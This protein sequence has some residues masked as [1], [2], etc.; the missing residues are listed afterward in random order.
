[1]Q[2]LPP[3]DREWKDIANSFWQ[4][5]NFPNCIGALDG[6]HMV[7]ECP[8]NSASKYYCYK[9]TFSIV[10]LGLV[11]ADYKF[12]VLDIGGL[13]KNSDGCIF[14]NSALG[15]SLT[16]N[17]LNVPRD[18]CLPGTEES[19]PLVIIG[20]AAFPLQRY[21]MRPYPANQ[22]INDE[23]KKVFNYRLSRARRVS[24]NAFGILARRFR[25]YERRLSLIPEHVNIVVAATCCLHNFLR[26]STTYWSEDDLRETVDE[27]LI[28]L[29]QLG[30]NASQAVFAM[31]DKFKNY[32]M[33]QFR[34]K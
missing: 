4:K 26:N 11:D 33:D 28:D 16:Q 17:K 2:L 3:T 21:L 25:I 30:G 22:T 12:T 34:G 9:K 14:A 32:L 29:P 23:R 20:D 24:E 31:R 7:I 19:M 8:P 6:K 10:L 27:G 1:M 15:K 5:W 13:G 18:A